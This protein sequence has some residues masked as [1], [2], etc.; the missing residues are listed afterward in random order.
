VREAKEIE[1]AIAVFA[2]AP[3]SGLI[4]PALTQGVVY[5]DLII[6]LAAKLRL[7]AVYPYRFQAEGGGLISYGPD[8]F[9][10][11]RLAAGYIDRVLKGESRLICPCRHRPNTSWSSILRPPRR[12]A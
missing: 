11:Y 7:P 10:Q 8:T 3:N 1:Q 5:R 2:R 12:S 9:E 6:S 4:V